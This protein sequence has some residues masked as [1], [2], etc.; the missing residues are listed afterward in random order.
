MIRNASV[1]V[2]VFLKAWPIIDPK[3]GSNIGP[4]TRESSTFKQ[5]LCTTIEKYE[6]IVQV[7][8]D[9]LNRYT[10]NQLKQQGCRVLH[11]CSTYFDDVCLCVEGKYGE[12][13]MIQLEELKKM[14]INHE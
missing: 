8:F 3:T 7:R 9:V 5:D 2:F 11:L 10:I 13:D 14:L 6:K 4:F 12:L 1:N